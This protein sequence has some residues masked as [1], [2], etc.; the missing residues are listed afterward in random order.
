MCAMFG[1]NRDVRLFSS[2][3]QELLHDIISQEVGYYKIDLDKS[4]VNVYGEGIE[5]YYKDPVLI[6]CLIERGDFGFQNTDTTLNVNRIITARFFR[7]DLTCADVV[8]EVG[9]VMMWNEDYFEV[10]NINENQLV[11][12]KDP[13]Y[14]YSDGTENF[15]SSWSIIVKAHYTRPDK[16]EISK[17]RL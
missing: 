16:F 17:N 3:N 6:T 10:D 15:G 11:V 7:E 1:G 4:N 14:S 12:G 5:K 8:P 13:S 9:D 2:L